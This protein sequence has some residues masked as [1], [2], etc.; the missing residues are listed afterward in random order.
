MTEQEED[1][2]LE[3]LGFENFRKL[4]DSEKVKRHKAK[5]LQFIT[6]PKEYDAYVKNSIGQ[7]I[8]LTGG[9][10]YINEKNAT[11]QYQEI[12]S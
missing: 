11:R 3:S 10:F 2:L 9:R 12:I 7:I 5:L 8:Q 6:P 1:E 4:P